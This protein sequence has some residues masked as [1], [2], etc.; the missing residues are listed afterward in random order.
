MKDIIFLP[1]MHYQVEKF[2]SDYEIK[3]KKILIVGAN[4]QGIVKYFD[5][6]NQI[7]VIIDDYENFITA[8]DDLSKEKNVSVKMMEYSATDY[9]KET[10]DIIY[11]QA[12]ISRDD[13]NQIIKEL[14]KI[15]KNDAIFVIGEVV[16][17][18]EKI[19]GF[20][21]DILVNNG[22][23]ADYI[24]NI[25]KYYIERKFDI[26]AK[27][28]LSYSLKEFYKECIK[29]LN[30]LKE[31]DYKE[32]SVRLSHEAN[33]FLKYGGDK[34]LGFLTLIMRKQA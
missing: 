2:T 15:A 27:I 31:D 13:K 22:L 23:A 24:E 11:A 12:S 7:E 34:H 29:L 28:D 26:I 33:A 32:L 18:Q 6:S 20:I 5:K 14:K 4:P 8:M 16:H 25:E 21:D 19:P 1:G 3:D 9:N 10:F 17:L 30:E